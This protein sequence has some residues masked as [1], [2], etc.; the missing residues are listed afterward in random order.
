VAGFSDKDV[1]DDKTVR[2]TDASSIGGVS[3]GNYTLSLVGAPTTTANITPSEIAAYL[4]IDGNTEMMTYTSNSLTI[5]AYDESGNVVTDYTGNKDLIFSGLSVSAGNN[6]TVNGIILGSATTLNFD[7]GKAV[8]SLIAYK[9]ESARL[10]VTDNIITS[11]PDFGISLNVETLDI[12]HIEIVYIHTMSDIQIFDQGFMFC[13]THGLSE[14]SQD[15]IR[16][17]NMGF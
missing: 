5:T 9:V 12:P 16:K 2:L 8:A 17:R 11:K 3:A 4:G 1:G 13:S 7:N 15:M 14:C 6:P 10:D